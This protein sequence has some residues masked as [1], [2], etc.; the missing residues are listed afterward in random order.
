MG[1]TLL[2]DP[3]AVEKAIDVYKRQ[4][5]GYALTLYGVCSACREASGS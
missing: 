2:T 5:E 1:T 4:I 3:T